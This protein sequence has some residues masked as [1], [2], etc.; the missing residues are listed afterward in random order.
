MVIIRLAK[1]M[2]K[3]AGVQAES[4]A[5]CKGGREVSK[6]LTLEEE[7]QRER[8]TGAREIFFKNKKNRYAGRM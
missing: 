8:P 5:T 7:E 3:H 2:L 4:E 1:K 6:L